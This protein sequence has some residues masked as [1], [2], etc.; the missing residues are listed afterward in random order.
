MLLESKHLA[1]LNCIKYV[2]FFM[3]SNQM[4]QPMSKQKTE[5]FSSMM[6]EQLA[7]LGIFWDILLNF[8]VVS[9]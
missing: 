1:M 8:A 3:A 4:H 9:S 7:V 5:I 6:E 2:A